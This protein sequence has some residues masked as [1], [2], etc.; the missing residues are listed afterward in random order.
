MWPRGHRGPAQLFV[1]IWLDLREQ[2]L[3][4]ASRLA[5]QQETLQS[6]LRMV[7]II[8]GLMDLERPG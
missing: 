3:P 1:S 8:T 6:F 2:R 7:E 4:G 5:S